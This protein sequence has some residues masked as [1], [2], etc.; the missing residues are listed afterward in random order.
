MSHWCCQV[1]GF[2]YD[3]VEGDDDS[4]IPPETP[5]ELVPSDWVCP[6]CGALKSNYKKID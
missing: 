2:V 1:C 4:G 6:E 3:P 5:F